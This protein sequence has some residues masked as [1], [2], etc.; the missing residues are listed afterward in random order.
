[1]EFGT[2]SI[3][4]QEATNNAEMDEVNRMWLQWLGFGMR[5]AG[6]TNVK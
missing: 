3:R 5:A 4:P 2:H 6:C 1:M